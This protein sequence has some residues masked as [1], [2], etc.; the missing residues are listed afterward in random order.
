MK[1]L[2]EVADVSI[3]D[4]LHLDNMDEDDG[5]FSIA[6]IVTFIKSDFRGLRLWFR[7]IQLTSSDFISEC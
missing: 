4:N 3:D 5:E 7:R 1:I 2:N 6:T